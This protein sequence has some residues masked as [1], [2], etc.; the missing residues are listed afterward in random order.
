[1]YLCSRKRLIT[2]MKE[3]NEQF[4]QKVLNVEKEEVVVLRNVHR[5][6]VSGKGFACPY[7]TIGINT[8][9]E[10]KAHYDLHEVV[11]KQ[12]DLAVVMPNHVLEQI[13]TS[14]DYSVT[15][16]VASA[17]FATEIKKR[18]LL[19]DYN[20]YH[21]SPA[22]HLSDEQA[23]QMMK[24]I[25]LLEIIT[26]KTPEEL[27]QRHELL[28]HMASIGFSLLSAFRND[29]DRSHWVLR[30]HVVFNEFCDLLALHHRQTH[31][32]LDYAEMLNLSPKYFSALVHKAVGVTASTW[33]NDYMVMQIKKVLTTRSDMTVQQVA[34]EFGFDE[35]ASFCR[36]F[37]HLTGVT[38]TRFRKMK[39]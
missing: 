34:Y 20:K 28:I 14:E 21:S 33:I 35:T 17:A 4:V 5:F 39:I 13:S 38:P 18:S 9:G 32:V 8:G 30:E 12:N 36:Y 2:P 25:D 24:V 6:P 27:P 1:M 29:Q 31:S 11:F 23:D 7:L 15:M 22:C 10:A 37:K 16:V 3:Q 19:H 26:Q